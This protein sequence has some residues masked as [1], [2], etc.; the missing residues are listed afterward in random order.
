MYSITIEGIYM[1]KF[2][3]HKKHEKEEITC[4]SDIESKKLFK[5]LD[6]NIKLLKDIFNN[7]N[8]IVTRSFI[9][10]WAKNTSLC[11]LYVDGMVNSSILNDN[12]IRAVLEYIPHDEEKNNASVDVLFNKVLQANK[13]TRQTEIEQITKNIII[14]ETILLVEGSDEAI[15]IS[16]MGWQTRAIAEPESER[17]VRGPRE[18]FIESMI[19]NLS[20][21]R[22]KL[23]T[24]D[25]KFQYKEIGKYSKTKICVC[26]LESIAS[27]KILKELLKRLDE[28]EI[29]GIL[30]SGYIQEMIKDSPLSPF[31]T[32]GD[33]ERPD[34]I[35]ARLLE[36]RIAL[37]VDGSPMVLT[38]PF[39]F[40]EYFQANEDYYNNYIFGSINRIL[41]VLGGFL[42]IS[43]PSI[44]VAIT[45]FQQEMIP[46]PLLLSIST[47]RRGVPF[48][49][50]VEAL[51]MVLTF[52]ILREA[53]TRLPSPVGQAVSIVGALVLGQAAVE[54]RLVSAPMIIVAALTGIT[55]LLIPKLAGPTIITRFFLLFSAAFLGLYGYIFGIIYL[56]IHLFGIRSFGVPYMLNV[57]YFSPQDIKD[58][59]IRA[60]WWYM[61]IRPKII[62]AKNLMRKPSSRNN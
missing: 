30:E 57:G 8:T 39:I 28:I 34:V 15:V 40:M 51:G 35:A 61:N 11:I 62:S 4:N 45:T 52:E 54:A 7:D 59:A 53:G 18:G 21:I 29:D 12:V 50:I 58:T 13:V 49:T 36:G 17:V 25:L 24:T 31:K 3:R 46:T 47:A 32:L 42:T 27:Q 44:Y 14:G 41:R 33:T 19:V 10:P 1:L 22:R 6:A 26:Y 23:Q 20:L 16:T 48:P 43:V 38:L 60:P 2:K 5:N 55:S 9:C 37:V 56:F